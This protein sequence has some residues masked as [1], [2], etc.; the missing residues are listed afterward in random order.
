GHLIRQACAVVDDRLE[1]C[2]GGH[3]HHLRRL[4]G[5]PHV[6]QPQG[7]P[8]RAALQRVRRAPEDLRGADPPL[9]RTPVDHPRGARRVARRPRRRGV[10]LVG[11]GLRRPQPQVRDEAHR[12]GDAL[13]A[14]DAVGRHLPA[15]VR[16]LPPAGVHLPRRDPRWGLPQPLPASGQRVLARRVVGHGGLPPRDA[17]AGHAPAPR[18]LERGA[19]AGV[20]QHRG[21]PGPLEPRGLRGRNGRGGRLRAHTPGHPVRNHRV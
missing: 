1:A 16:G 21:L 7:V 4:P 11:T 19:D 20:D 15:A 5:A 2:D 14:H 10:H 3:R 6:R 18:G 8:G 9:L 13:L 12:G 17:G